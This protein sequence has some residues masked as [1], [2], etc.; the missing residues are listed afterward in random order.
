MRQRRACRCSSNGMGIFTALLLV[1]SF[2]PA[3]Q[4]KKLISYGSDWPN[5]AYVRQHIREMEKHPFDGIVI[6]VSRSR[7]PQISGSSLGIG[8]WGEERFAAADFE[9]CIEDLRATKFETFTDN[10]IQLET[11]PGDVDWFDPQWSSVIENVRILARVAKQGGCMGIEFDPEEYSDEHIFSYTAWPQARRHG[12]SQQQYID[13]A[14]VRGRELMRAINAEFPR[15]KILCLFGPALTA[16]ST[17][18]TKHDYRLLAPFLEGM[19]QAADEGPEIIDGFEQ[20]YG[21]RA[22]IAFES[23]RRDMIRARR[24]FDDKAAFDRVMRVGFGLWTDFRSGQDGWFPNDPEKNHFQPETW[25]NAVNCALSY[26]DRYVWLW[27]EK[28]HEWEGRDIGEAYERAQ[29]AGRE[30]SVDLVV[31]QRPPR[32]SLIGRMNGAGPRDDASVFGP[33][34]ATHEVLVDLRDGWKFRP[35]PQAVGVNERWFAIDAS[36]DWSPIHIGRFW[37]EENWDYDGAGWYRTSFTFEPKKNQPVKLAIG[38]ADE[39]VTAW[40]NGQQVGSNDDDGETVWDRIVTFD[41]T[42]ALKPG[43]NQLT[44]RVLDRTGPGGLWR[45]V[46]L[47]APK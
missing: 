10:F 16:A 38:G 40:L 2:H 5:T 29:Y 46:K 17:P 25:Q 8:A 33:L 37:E 34:L 47:L 22:R 11:M 41:V 21:Y 23:G 31:H 27:R 12:R 30:R 15:I 14:R 44:L 9:H 36:K 43:E 42:S 32:Q 18:D 3:T 1:S 24:V 28:I 19:C 6:A 35:D 4:D 45:G 26:S 39:T 13:Q 20:S 7:E